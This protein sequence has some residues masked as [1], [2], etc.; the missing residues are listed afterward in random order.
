MWQFEVVLDTHTQALTD[1]LTK[2]AVLVTPEGDLTPLA[3][4]ADAPGGHHREGI[5]SFKA[6]ASQPTT[7]SIRVTRAGRLGKEPV[8]IA[9]ELPWSASVNRV[10]LWPVADGLGEATERTRSLLT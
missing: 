2:T 8:T 4:R 9:R 7:I 3:W 10:V 1:D 6:P 5:L